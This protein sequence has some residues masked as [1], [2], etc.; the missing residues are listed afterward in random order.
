MA[1]STFGLAASA[2][3]ASRASVRA[4]KGIRIVLSPQ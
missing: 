1:A 3:I 4:A 2:G